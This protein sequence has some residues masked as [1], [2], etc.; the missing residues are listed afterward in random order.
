[1]PPTIAIAGGGIA[2]LATAAALAARGI[3]ATLF[4][5][6]DG[7][8]PQGAGIALQANAVLALRALGLEAPLAGRA[9]RIGAVTARSPRGE[10]LARVDVGRVAGSLGSACLAVSRHD[11]HS[12]LLD[13]AR[14]QQL[15]F[16]RAVIRVALDPTPSSPARAEHSSC[17]VEFSSGQA[18]RFDALIGA[19]GV[20]SAVRRSLGL[21]TGPRYAGYRCWR[22]LAA[23]PGLWP[24]DEGSGWWGRGLAFGCFPLPAG[25]L[26][27]YATQRWG[28]PDAAEAADWRSTLTPLF[29]GWDPRI[30]A[31][32]AATPDAAVTL[33]PL[34]DRR[35]VGPWGAGPVALVG[36]AAHPVTPSLGQ[37]GGL[38]LEDAVVLAATLEQAN[39]SGESLSDALRRF[40]RRRRGRVAW[41]ARQ[42]RRLTA[43]AHAQGPWGLLAQRAAPWAPRFLRER[44]ARR[45]YRFAPPPGP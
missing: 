13:A 1:M 41:I 29:R 15:V 37:G 23:A 20:G 10:P 21:A 9:Q 27:W 44:Q 26:Y 30:G 7:P 32:L 31:M 17:C 38:A 25:V 39:L 40:E 16:G 34:A 33:T 2:G 22:G 36:D 14:G 24:E 43:V 5:A 6:S 42:S 11:L 4:E 3:R 12:V 35:P 28:A 8:R 18:E 19:D 45:L